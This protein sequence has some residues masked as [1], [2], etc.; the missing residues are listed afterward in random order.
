MAAKISTGAVNQFGQMVSGV[1]G[2]HRQAEG[3]AN[4]FGQMVSGVRG[5]E[6]RQAEGAANQFGQMVSGEGTLFIL[7]CFDRLSQ[8]EQRLGS[9]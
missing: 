1:R 9:G 5:G 2:K 4:Q 8:H 3:A 6:H 7:R